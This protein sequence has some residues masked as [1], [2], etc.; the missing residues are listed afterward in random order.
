MPSTSSRVVR[1]GGRRRRRSAARARSSRRVALRSASRSET[2]ES[3]RF[4]FERTWKAAVTSGKPQSQC[5][6]RLAC[7]ARPA[8][9]NAFTYGDASIQRACDGAHHGERADDKGNGPSAPPP[10]GHRRAR[11]RVRRAGVTE[12]PPPSRS[13]SHRGRERIVLQVA[14]RA[15]SARPPPAAPRRAPAAHV[16]QPCRRRPCRRP[17]AASTAMLLARVPRRNH[18]KSRRCMRSSRRP[19]PPRSALA[20]MSS[21]S[22]CSR[23]SARTAF[24]SAGVSRSGCRAARSPARGLLEGGGT[25]DRRAQ[26]VPRRASRAR[27]MRCAGC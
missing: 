8:A 17:K 5:A 16:E 10:R 9:T 13:A 27:A 26:Y 14:A 24:R 25:P 2:T 4:D 12:L 7:D 15:R 11:E 3:E 20:S 21:T 6:S 19:A 1:G 23:R 22:R 18:S